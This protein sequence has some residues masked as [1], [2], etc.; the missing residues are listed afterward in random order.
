MIII[1]IVLVAAVAALIAT[2]LR[3]RRLLRENQ[4]L[5]A[6]NTTI[7]EYMLEPTSP[8]SLTEEPNN[9][10]WSNPPIEDTVF[11][12][13]SPISY[14]RVILN[15][16]HCKRCKLVHRYIVSGWDL[17]KKKGLLDVEGFYYAGIKVPN[18]GCFVSIGKNN[19]GSESKSE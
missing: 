8:G 12:S 11:T 13:R 19:N 6:Q 5:L 4:K 7:S 9:H 2:N 16:S 10:D 15:V 14:E 18:R 1:D 3:D 17:A